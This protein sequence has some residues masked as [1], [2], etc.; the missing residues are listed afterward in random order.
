[1]IQED[2][3]HI[4]KSVISNKTEAILKSLPI[5]KSPGSDGVI[6]DSTRHLKNKHQRFLEYSLRQK[7][8]EH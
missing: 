1:L 8:K 2:I 7:G 3:N 5:R 4:N 6:A